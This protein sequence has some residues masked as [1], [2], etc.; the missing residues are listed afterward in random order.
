MAHDIIRIAQPELFIG[1]VAPIGTDI[2]ASINSFSKYFTSEGY[3]VVPIKVTEVFEKIASYLPPKKKLAPN[4]EARRLETYIKYGNQLRATF[5][6][7][8]ILAAITITRIIQR[9]RSR[10]SSNKALA[11]EKNVY[12]LY[13]FKR[14]EE[15]DLL[16]SVYGRA[17]FQV[18]VYS[19]RGA[20]VDNLSRR[21]A[22][23]HNRGNP[24]SYRGAAEEVVQKDENESDERHGQRVSRI[25][26]D[27][28][29]IVNSD[30]G[31]EDVDRQIRRFC[32]LLFG[33]NKISPTRSEY[34][35]F[36]AKAAALRTLDLS[37]QVGVA[38]FSSDG[39]IISMGSNE[40]PKAGGGTYWCDDPAGND[41]RDYQRGHDANDK[42]KAQ[43]LQ[44]LFELAGLRNAKKLLD[45]KKIQDSQ[46]M[47]ALEYGRIIHAEMSAICD[48]A[49]L[50]RS[51]QDAVLFTTT[52]PC[53]LCAK[54]IVAAG[55]KKVVFLEP[56]P[57]SLASTLHSDSI[58]IEGA[59]RGKYA[60]FDGVSFE[61]FDG[62]SP[63]RYRELFERTSRK[64][65]S[66][67]QEW[68]NNV[69]Q[70]IVDL[71]FPFYLILEDNILDS[72]TK[73]LAKINM[74]VT[75]L[76]GVVAKRPLKKISKARS[77][78][79]RR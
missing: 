18:S 79:R 1:F 56:Y 51:V 34:G 11:P 21:F 61:H 67:F 69:K 5:D 33:S 14:R 20:R 12:L 48:A 75:A 41:D 49:R 8:Q 15:I 35:M 3:N 52:F 72:T 78:R 24:N 22:E 43:L 74:P 25:F 19:R 40:V 45:D 38:I 30:K 60:A 44:E 55:I 29:V 39:E 7:D 28:D 31:E 26:H 54:H 37:R 42:R 23:G 59:D 27:A 66:E 58:I 63:R 6:D 77:P 10:V 53:H 62:V 71:K 17:F 13:Q 64:R 76:E 47:D 73:S 65:L 32:D 2:R 36:A 16:R 4:P 46:F 57:K 68:I 50:G 70:P 9:R